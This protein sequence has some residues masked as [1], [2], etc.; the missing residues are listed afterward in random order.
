[1]KKTKYCY[2]SFMQH[3]EAGDQ[4]LLTKGDLLEFYSKTGVKLH[5]EMASVYGNIEQIGY[6]WEYVEDENLPKWFVYL[7]PIDVEIED[8]VIKLESVN[9]YENGMNWKNVN[10]SPN[11]RLRKP[12]K[13]KADTKLPINP[14][15]GLRD[16]GV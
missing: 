14:K 6:T 5:V 11:A 9:K 8:E 3:Y 10:R 4:A 15:T 2:S 12:K 16:G 7:G 1:M 13:P